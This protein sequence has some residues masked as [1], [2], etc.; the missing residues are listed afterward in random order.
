MIAFA[1]YEAKARLLKILAVPL[2]ILLIFQFLSYTGLFIEIFVMRNSSCNFLTE[3]DFGAARIREYIYSF[4]LFITFGV[5]FFFL[6]ETTFRKKE[7]LPTE[8]NETIKFYARRSFLVFLIAIYSFVAWYTGLLVFE[9]FQDPES[10]LKPAVY[11]CFLAFF[12]F[13]SIVA[14]FKYLS[15]F[16]YPFLLEISKEGINLRG[17]GL[18]K[19]HAIDKIGGFHMTVIIKGVP[20]SASR[21]LIQYRITANH[22]EQAPIIGRFFKGSYVRQGHKVRRGFTTS[23]I[24]LN[25]KSE[26]IYQ[27]IVDGYKEYLSEKQGYDLHSRPETMDKEKT[28]NFENALDGVFVN[29]NKLLKSM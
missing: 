28:I 7:T 25:A 6:I 21:V 9:F 17:A 1:L 14:V 24:E 29:Y 27:A 16:I 19:W 18:I 4:I 22:I 8:K 13:G 3:G 11:L 20:V 23:G 10:D 15:F 26:A 12:S 2:L 5:L